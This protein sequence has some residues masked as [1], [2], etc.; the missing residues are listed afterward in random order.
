M[1]PL[2]GLGVEWN[3]QGYKD[4]APPGL[5]AYCHLPTAYFFSPT[6]SIVQRSPVRGWALAILGKCSVK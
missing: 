4:R 6:R 3:N 5:T 1:S 2:T